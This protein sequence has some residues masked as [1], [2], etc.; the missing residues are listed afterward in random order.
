MNGGLRRPIV[1]VLI[2]YLTVAAAG[3]GAHWYAGTQD[4]TAAKTLKDWYLYRSPG[5]GKLNHITEG[6]V[7]LPSLILGLAMGV[8]TS[9]RSKAEFAWHVFLVPVGITVLQPLYFKFF[10]EHPWWSMNGVERAGA[11]GVAH[12]RALMF[13]CV[14]G[15]V[16]RTSA[17]QAQGR[18]PDQ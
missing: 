5:N 11:L 13:V 16:G 9:R 17:Q 1:G 4:G 18:V 12:A 7:L 15:I 14:A 6:D 8:I 2:A 3:L 10:S